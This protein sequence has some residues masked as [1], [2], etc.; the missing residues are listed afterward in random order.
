[1]PIYRAR[2][3]TLITVSV[4][5]LALMCCIG[6]G[7]NSHQQRAVRILFIGN[8]YTYFNNLPQIVTEL[9][10]Y[11][12]QPAVETKME[13]P[14]G[15]RL[16]DHWEKGEA[17]KALHDGKWDYVV[18]QDQ[19]TLGLDYF[20]QG[21]DRVTSDAIFRPFA[22]KWS[23]EISRQGARPVFYLTWA[24]KAVPEDQNALNYAYMSAARGTGAV[25][26]PVGLAW[27]KAGHENPSIELY[28][29]DGSH[30]S[31]AGS[32]L[33]ACTF[34]ATLFHQSPIGLPGKIVGTPVNLETEKPEPDKK[35]VLVDLPH[36]QVRAL[37]TSAWEAC[38]ELARQGGYLPVSTPKPPGLPD[39]P[40]GQPLAAADLEGTWSGELLFYP[41]YNHSGPVEMVLHLRRENSSWRGHLEIKF[42]A[43]DLADEAF[44]LPDLNVSAREITFT[45][46]KSLDNLNIHFQ[47][48]SPS[49]GEMVGHADSK[50]EGPDSRSSQ[51]LGSWR[52]HKNKN[53]N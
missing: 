1:M 6:V 18:L 41:L 36:D 22:E 33:A 11:G 53:N 19:S 10:R 39:L 28:Y 2:M 35:A 45:D 30:P 14:G 42:H 49:R 43:K 12:H 27:E 46:P 7:G 3:K 9:A 32:Y 31:S 52:L 16:K 4:A 48:L 40:S 15:F 23:A 25:V 50:L 8:S 51:F 29:K 13:A 5:I 20:L 38:E 21:Q 37:Q 24:R 26:A 47:G 44:D 34:Y 17:L